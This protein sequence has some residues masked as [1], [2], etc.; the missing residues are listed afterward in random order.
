MALPLH[1]ADAALVNAVAFQDLS[2]VRDIL[3]LKSHAKDNLLTSCLTILRADRRD[4]V[5]LLSEHG[6]WDWSVSL[7]YAP[8]SDD[9]DFVKWFLLDH[10]KCEFATPCQVTEPVMSLSRPEGVGRCAS[11]GRVLV[12]DQVAQLLSCSLL[13]QNNVLITWFASELLGPDAPKVK[14]STIYDI[15]RAA[16]IADR[17]D[18]IVQVLASKPPL[19]RP[20]HQRV[21]RD[22]WQLALECQSRSVVTFLS[23]PASEHSRL[24]GTPLYAI[25]FDSVSA[26]CASGSKTFVEWVLSNARRDKVNNTASSANS[27]ASAPSLTVDDIR[28]MNTASQVTSSFG[29]SPLA[30]ACGAAPHSVIP[31][32]VHVFFPMLRSFVER[33]NV[34]PISDLAQF[35]YSP[36]AYEAMLREQ[37]PEGTAGD[38]PLLLLPRVHR[39]PCSA[40]DHPTAPVQAFLRSLGCDTSTG[41]V[42][43]LLKPVRGGTLGRGEGGEKG[44]GRLAE[45]EGPAFLQEEP[46]LD[47]YSHGDSCPPGLER[48]GSDNLQNLAKW[49]VL[50][51]HCNKNESAVLALVQ[52]LVEEWGE[53]INY[54]SAGPSPLGIACMYGRTQVVKY[55]LDKRADPNIAPMERYLSDEEVFY[56]AH[57][58]LPRAPLNYAIAGG[59]LDIVPLLVEAKA[60]VMGRGRY[61]TPAAVIAASGPLSCLVFFAR[62]AK[63]LS[64]TS[65]SSA[66]HAAAR[67]GRLDNVRFL[68]EDLKCRVEGRDKSLFE[69]AIASD[70]VALLR[71]LEKKK[72]L[73]TKYC[74]T[75]KTPDPAVPYAVAKLSHAAL[76]WLVTE[77]RSLFD[78]NAVSSTIAKDTA[79]AF[80]YWCYACCSPRVSKTTSSSVLSSPLSPQRIA[81]YRETVT[82][83]AVLSATS[84]PD[85]ARFAISM[86]LVAG[87]N[88]NVE[89]VARAERHHSTVHHRLRLCEQVY[90]TAVRKQPLV[91]A[92]EHAKHSEVD[93]A[94]SGERK[95]SATM[96]SV[97]S[98][99]SSSSPSTTSSSSSS[100]QRTASSTASVSA[101]RP[102]PTAAS[103]RTHDTSFVTPQ[104]TI[105]LRDIKTYL[106]DLSLLQ[107]GFTSAVL[108]PSPHQHPDSEHLLSVFTVH[109]TAT[110]VQVLL[111]DPNAR[112]AVN[113][114]TDVGT[115]PLFGLLAFPF[116]AEHSKSLL[117]QEKPR[118]LSALLAAGADPSV[119]EP[120]TGLTCIM[121]AGWR[122]DHYRDVYDRLLFMM[123]Q[124]LSLVY[125][126]V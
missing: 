62:E 47:N 31:N 86:G 77:R 19:D 61:H 45:K 42:Y 119:P 66:V 24:R 81:F 122:N 111:T 67:A 92:P 114:P 88:S 15:Y 43:S 107:Y 73:P 93:V 65:V 48:H 49:L 95:S 100:T 120:A 22:L 36:D 70:N 41:R 56:T 96:H 30:R 124:H 7:T 60:D 28:E 103:S 16:V 97:L 72:T 75:S 76:R 51:V 12:A 59:H 69:A 40:S 11:E 17:P 78:E 23:D 57:P 63:S 44:V 74:I 25:D 99:P 8:I 68:L 10:L 121:L 117:L 85:L 104:T 26:A 9:D 101:S 91:F 80:L 3:L 2:T 98:S 13:M 21:F 4:A 6:D 5:L 37:L 50:R 94:D 53:R 115:T 112:L 84:T 87:D 83:F 32:I 18:I 105:H 110:A 58:F 27:T 64:P 29:V 54:P 116:A 38:P 20:S 108:R 102:A 33:S 35:G 1:A 90:A 123:L 71:Y 126:D 113:R 52:W 39:A 125:E 109:G 55:L 46:D 118:I 82:R 34:N 89:T 79:N 14:S 106:R